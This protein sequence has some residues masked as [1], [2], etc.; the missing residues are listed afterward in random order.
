LDSRRVSLESR[1]GINLA[2]SH[3]ALITLP[4]QSRKQRK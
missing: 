2:P 3:N 1:N 4:D